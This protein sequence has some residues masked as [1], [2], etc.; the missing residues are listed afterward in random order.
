MGYLF[1]YQRYK[2]NFYSILLCNGLLL[3][4]AVTGLIFAFQWFGNGVYA[5]IP[6]VPN[7]E[8]VT[9]NVLAL[10]QNS[11]GNPFDTFD[12]IK[13]IQAELFQYTIT[14]PTKRSNNYVYSFFPERLKGLN[15]FDTYTV[16]AGTGKLESYELWN[17]L[18]LKQKIKRAEYNIHVGAIGGI[19]TKII[20]FL[21][22]LIAASLPVTG[23]FM[24]KN[25]WKKSK[26]R[27]FVIG[28]VKSN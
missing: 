27:L 23:F 18:S 14:Y 12:S 28:Y 15:N 8:K 16:N 22:C 20:A 1:I 6:N 7:N 25:K 4:I 9:Q 24:W 26:K 3:F 13:D 5:L 19:I 21:A 11:T 2:S 17:T 10:E